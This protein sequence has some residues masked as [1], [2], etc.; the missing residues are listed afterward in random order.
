M[1]SRILAENPE[2]GVV[3]FWHDD[4]ATGQIIVEN[5]VD[6]E[7]VIAANKDVTNLKSGNWKGDMHQVASIPIIVY[8]DLKRRGIVDDQPRFRQ[9]LNDA[10]NRF[11]R[12]KEGVV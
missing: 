4:D 7:S 10:D 6:V 8:D 3:T 12:T 9:W 5:R 2:T 1:R 11:F